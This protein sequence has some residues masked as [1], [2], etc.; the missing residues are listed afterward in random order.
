MTTQTNFEVP[1]Q[2][3]ELFEKSIEQARNAFEAL[4][5]A[6]EKMVVSVEPLLPSGSREVN[7]KAFSFSHANI[8]AAFDFAQELAR[9]KDAQRF[10]QLNYDFVKARF[11]TF[12]EQ[13]VELRTTL[14]KAFAETKETQKER[15]DLF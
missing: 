12:Q 2:A 14:Q 10:M 7:V 1:P 3:Q 4:T 15:S 9:A 11:A 5:S 13:E 6:A 8:K